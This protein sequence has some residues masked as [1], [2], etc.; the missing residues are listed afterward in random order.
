MWNVMLDWR[1]GNINRTQNCLC[2]T[3]L[4]IIILVH[5]GTSSSSR[6]VDWIGL[7]SCLVYLPSISVCSVFLLYYIKNFLLYSLLYFLVS[8]SWLIGPWPLTWLTNH[9]PSVLWHCWLVIWPVKSSPKWPI[10]CRVGHWTLLHHII[11][12]S[13]LGVIWF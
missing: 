4:C 7:W 13:L 6:S 1:K 9:R 2:A 5:S 10:M 3:V 11:H 12:E 8:W